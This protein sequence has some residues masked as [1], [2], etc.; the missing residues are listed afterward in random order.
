MTRLRG[1]IGS[2][3]LAALCLSAVL[4]IAPGRAAEISNVR[5]GVTSKTATR[6]VIDVSAAA[7]YSISVEGGGAGIIEIDFPSAQT[8]AI[9][10]KGAGHVSDFALKQS[11]AGGKLTLVLARPAV[12]EKQFEIAPGKGAKQFRL[13][14]DLMDKP[15]QAA[16]INAPYEDLTEMLQTVVPVAPASVE[17]KVDEPNSLPVIVIDPGHGGT[18]PGA[19]STAGV[20]EKA[21]TL[22]AGKRL[23]E[24]LQTRN[25]Y[26]IVL[27]RADDGRLGL[28]QRAKIA[29]D[30]GADLFISL[31]ADAHDDTEVRGGSIYTLSEVGTER[32]AREAQ[33]SGNYHDVYGQDLEEHAPDV[34]RIMYDVAQKATVTRSGQFAELLLKRLKGAT[35]LLNNS[36]RVADL[37]VLLSP[38]VPAVLFELAFISNDKDAA[39]LE[40]PA[41]RTKTM[42]AVADSIDDYFHA[43]SEARRAAG[44]PSGS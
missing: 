5:F 36:H 13:V 17:V 6:V 35:P 42:T 18:D 33:T 14:L 21:M 15:K 40:S 8:A 24:I 1:Q 41:W 9:A 22:A 29:R 3:G 23:S 19:S 30:A 34:G 37:R 44:A 11:Q 43:R 39:N 16:A 2:G 27:T 32:S 31:H 28:E 38:D 25:R 7:K 12:I 20:Q 26:Q 10:G 4:L